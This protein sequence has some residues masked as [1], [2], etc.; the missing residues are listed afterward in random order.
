MNGR[1][2][3][4]MPMYIAKSVCIITIGSSMMCRPISTLLM[5]PLLRRSPIHAYTRTRN[6]V[7]NGRMISSNRMFRQLASD[8][9]MP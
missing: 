7:Q 1:Y 3:Y 5:R 6:E 8:R 9:A 2:E 4:T